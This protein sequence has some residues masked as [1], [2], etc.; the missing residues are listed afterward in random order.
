MEDRGACEAPL[1][2]TCEMVLLTVSLLRKISTM[3]CGDILCYSI[4]LLCFHSGS[5]SVDK[6]LLASY[7]CCA[8]EADSTAVLLARWTDSAKRNEPQAQERANTV[9]TFRKCVNLEARQQLAFIQLHAQFCF[10]TR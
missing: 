7:H 2:R 8:V 10:E 6:Q 9:I 1:V 3:S 5:N 4:V